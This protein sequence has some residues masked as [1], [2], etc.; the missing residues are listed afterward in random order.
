MTSSASHRTPDSETD[1]T[2]AVR[3]ILRGFDEGVFVRNIDGDSDPAWAIKL[4]P[5]IRAIGVAQRIVS[6]RCCC[7]AHGPHEDCP[8]HGGPHCDTPG[9]C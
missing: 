6:E 3:M 7:P 8:V 1:F 2:N 5:F 9:G 4:M